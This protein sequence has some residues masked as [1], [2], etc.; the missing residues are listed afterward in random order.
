M[1]F[2]EI[3]GHKR[4]IDVLRRSIVSGQ[5]PPAYLFHGDEGIG[6]RLVALQMAKALNC[7]GERAPGESCGVCRSC[8]NID[9]GCH[10]NVSHMAIEVNEKTGK[11]RQ[12]IVIGQ[13]RMAQEY[14]SLKAVGE[15]RK[16]LIVDG[17]HLMN[18]EAANAFLKTL[19]EPPDG[20]HIVLVT[21]RPSYLLP[22]IMSRSRAVGF[23]P[24]PEKDVASALAA[25]KGMPLPDA[26]FVARMTGGRLGAALE[27]E[28][29]ELAARRGSFLELLDLIAAYDDAKLLAKAEELSKTDDGLE[30]VVFFGTLW[31]RD[32]LVILVGGSV[33]IA[34]NGDIVD[35]LY[36]WA[37]MT[38]AYGC[39]LALDM[40]GGAGRSLERTYNR[41]LMAEDLFFRIREDVLASPALRG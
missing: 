10:P 17:A 28:P 29:S 31:F 32:L 22:T 11:T 27:A 38:T 33:E 34:Y 2:S 1:S 30:D 23:A 20:S 5:L 16:V 6:K 14:L 39:E 25:K 13:V 21:S 40:L 35:E 24:L 8:K 9:S 37:S 4:Q 15:G 36:A 3:L 12:E 26:M 7:T 41:R 19:E 18:E